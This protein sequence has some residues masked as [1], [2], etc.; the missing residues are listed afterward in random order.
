[1]NVVD[2]WNTD[3]GYAHPSNT[4]D[5]S[6]ITETKNASK[7]RANVQVGG[8]SVDMLIDTGADKSLLTYTFFKKM[9]YTKQISPTTSRFKSYTHH[10]IKTEGTVARPT[11][12]T[13]VYRVVKYYIVHVDQSPLL[14]GNASEELGIIMRIN[15][16]KSGIDNYPQ[17]Q[18][19]TATLPGTYTLQIDPTMPPV[20]H[21]PRGHCLSSGTQNQGQSGRS[22]REQAYNEDIRAN[23]LGELN[24]HNM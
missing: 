19:T 17:L 6:K 18:K 2:D 16:V 21:A 24:G 10:P 3:E 5:S 7:W 8:H 9:G 1:M 14:S 12:Y 11:V 13:G 23:R 15:T 20:V 4:V 22:G